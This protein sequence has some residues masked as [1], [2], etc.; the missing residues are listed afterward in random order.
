MKVTYQDISKRAFEIWER[1]G[2]REG[3]DQEYW[4]QAEEELQREAE[5]GQK[6]QRSARQKTH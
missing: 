5:K 1:E 2:K 4:F 3:R 6:P